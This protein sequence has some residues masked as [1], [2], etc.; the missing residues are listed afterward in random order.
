MK[1]IVILLILFYLTQIISA[2]SI[3]V[4]YPNEVKVGE[5]FNII[6]ELTEM[7]NEYELYDIKIDVV[8]TNGRIGRIYDENEDKWKSTYYYIKNGYNVNE[9]NSYKMIV[10]NY[11]GE[12]TILIKVRDEKGKI[13]NFDEYKIEVIGNNIEE[14]TEKNITKIFRKNETIEIIGDLSL[15]KNNSETKP[16]E[17]IEL[18]QNLKSRDDVGI[19]EKVNNIKSAVYGLVLLGLFV[20][21][22]FLI[23]YL[24]NKTTNKNGIA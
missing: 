7:S 19:L 21:L 15:K 2:Q 22:L 9:K 6:I 17:I 4:D 18:S 11:E 23:R 20:I 12:G 3:N 8:G 10:N 13:Y 14:Q 5:E 1:R 16:N 24:K